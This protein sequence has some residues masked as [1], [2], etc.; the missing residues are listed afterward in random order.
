MKA[1]VSRGWTNRY[2]HKDFTFWEK[3][4]GILVLVKLAF[5][6]LKK[7]NV[8]HN[9]LLFFIHFSLFSGNPAPYADYLK[10]L[11]TVTCCYGEWL[12][13]LTVTVWWEQS[14]HASDDPWHNDQ[15]LQHDLKLCL[16]SRDGSLP[17]QLTWPNWI[18]GL[19][20]GRRFNSL[21]QME[22]SFMTRM[23]LF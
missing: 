6:W 21:E 2:V 13:A 9:S 3:I 18:L 19:Q 11:V 16:C 15:S 20:S 14:Q 17:G 1:K 4:C 10:P 22:F 23:L 12:E 8:S 7:K 5:F